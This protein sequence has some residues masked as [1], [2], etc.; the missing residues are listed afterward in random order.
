[1]TITHRS[2]LKDKPITIRNAGIDYVGLP[3]AVEVGER[4]Q[5]K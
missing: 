1:M 3:P 2:Q 5:P 4:N